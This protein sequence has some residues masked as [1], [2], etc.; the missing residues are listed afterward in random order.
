MHVLYDFGN[1]IAPDALNISVIALIL[2]LEL[3]LLNNQQ[4]CFLVRFYL[5]SLAERFFKL[6]SHCLGWTLTVS[7][8]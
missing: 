8:I 3:F 6:L 4:I 2:P 5:K 1:P 7:L